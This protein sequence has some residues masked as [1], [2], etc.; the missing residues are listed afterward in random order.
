MNEFPMVSV[1]VPVYNTEPFLGQCLDSLLGQSC[2]SLEIICINDGS[3]DG[4][5]G[6]LEDFRERDT[7]VR[8]LWQEHLGKSVALNRGIE[9]ARGE[10]LYFCDSDDYLAPEALSVAGTRARNDALDMLF[11]N[12]SVVGDGVS[13]ERVRDEQ[14]YFR[15]TGEYPGIMRGSELFLRLSERKEYICTVYQYLLRREFLLGT[16]LKFYQIPVH[17]DEL[18][19]LPC[20]MKAGRVGYLDEAFYTRRLR[21]GSAFLTVYGLESVR[22]IL[23]AAVRAAESLDVDCTR[24]EKEAVIRY[25]LRLLRIG[26]NRFAALTREEQEGC[27]S[28]T[29]PEQIY[30]RMAM[31]GEALRHELDR[32]SAS[33]AAAGGGGS[34][35]GCLVYGAGGRLSDIL[36]EHPDFAR[37]I[38]RIF[39]KS[40]ERRGTFLPGTGKLIESPVNLSGLPEGTDIY[41]SVIRYYDEISED[42]RRINPGL[43]CR[44]LEELLQSDGGENASD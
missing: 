31:Q 7:R 20:L 15:R 17:E 1:I 16:G 32:L 42:I 5:Q 19:T 29:L 34:S 39:D 26:R 23:L 14:Q 33:L 41:I 21:E 25:L 43:V 10:Y 38:G 35:G 12:V 6:I 28:W 13:A 22:C 37:R 4:S 44:S 36:D 30:F 40:E 9:M 2:R 3:T 8:I 27:R 11:F 18:F 24:E